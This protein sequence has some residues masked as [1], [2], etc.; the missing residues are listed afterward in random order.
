M[1]LQMNYQEKYEQGIE[2]GIER[3]KVETVRRL[4]E[5]NKFSLE[6]IAAGTGLSIE[7]V[8]EITKLQPV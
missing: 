6:D 1:T 7:K 8:K 4:I 3:E 5:M 2:Q